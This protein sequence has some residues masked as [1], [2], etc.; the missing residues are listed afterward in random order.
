MMVPPLHTTWGSAP[1][2][3]LCSGLPP[4]RALWGPSGPGP[5]PRTWERDVGASLGLAARYRGRREAAPGLLSSG[6]G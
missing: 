6:P 2:G 4:L 1:S 5:F 3:E